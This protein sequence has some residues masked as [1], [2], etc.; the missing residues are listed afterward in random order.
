MY[1]RIND[2]LQPRIL[3]HQRNAPEFPVGKKS[4]SGRL[5]PLNQISCAKQLLGNRPLNE[6]VVAQLLAGPGTPLPAPPPQN[7][8]ESLWQELLSVTGEQKRARDRQLR[9]RGQ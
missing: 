6:K 1:S 8:D 2:S 9:F 7:P 5:K 4:S 3:G